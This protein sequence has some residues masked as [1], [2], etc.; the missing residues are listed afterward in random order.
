MKDINTVAW[1]YI[2]ELHYLMKLVLLYSEKSQILFKAHGSEHEK[3]NWDI[4]VF[5]TR[6]DTNATSVDHECFKVSFKT[7]MIK[8]V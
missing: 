1:D 8:D 6:N 7:K 5:V 2:M 3:E 4:L